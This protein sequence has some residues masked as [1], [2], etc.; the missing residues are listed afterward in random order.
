MHLAI[1]EDESI[2]GQLLSSYI[3][4]WSD[5]RKIPI[6]L[7]LFEN[8]E[9]F[10]FQWED[11][12]YDAVF[13]DIQMTG[14]NGM[15]LAHKI[16][17]H[18]KNISLIFTTGIPDY[19]EEGYEVNALHYLRKPLNQEKVY[20]CLDKVSSRAKSEHF[21]ILQTPENNIQKIAQEHILYIEARG[22]ETLIQ[23]DQGQSFLCK[24]SISQLEKMLDAKEF[25]KCHRSYLCRISAIYRI[26]KDTIYFEN[27]Y[28]I[29]V[30][31]RV[32]Q[33]VNQAFIQY[34]RK[35]N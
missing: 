15:E 5:S 21:I 6:S 32:Y 16:R 34:Y 29:P 12:H 14:M 20:A 2:H 4:N 35:F 23:P 25:I 26:D 33:A 30:S 24:N 1:V 8:A 10:L 13:L 19:I 22:H 31:R 17:S 3:K 7:A 28:S 9:Q 11:T 18:D 27:G